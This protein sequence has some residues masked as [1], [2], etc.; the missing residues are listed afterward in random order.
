MLLGPL[1]TI[2]SRAWEIHVKRR[3][4]RALSVSEAFGQ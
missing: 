2:F 3:L 1:Y 4:S